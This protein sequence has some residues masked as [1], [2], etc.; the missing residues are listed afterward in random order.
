MIDYQVASTF[1]IAESTLGN[2][3][4]SQPPLAWAA[5]LRIAR[6]D[7]INE[8]NAT[9]GAFARTAA[10]PIARVDAETIAYGNLGD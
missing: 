8:G 3:A 4:K 6:R 9:V 2:S 5:Q 1:Q 10:T 7:N